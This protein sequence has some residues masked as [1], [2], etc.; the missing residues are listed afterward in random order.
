[1]NTMTESNTKRRGQKATPDEYAAKQAPAQLSVKRTT[2]PGNTIPDQL[3]RQADKTATQP[4][5][6]EEEK[7]AETKGQSQRILTLSQLPIIKENMLNAS[8]RTIY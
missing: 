8:E 7:A 4:S 5:V 6:R 1:M 2:R 3:L